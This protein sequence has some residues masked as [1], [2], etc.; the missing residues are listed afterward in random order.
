MTLRSIV[1]AG[2]VMSA[3]LMTLNAQVDKKRAL[4]AYERAIRLE[5]QGEIDASLKALDEA[6]LADPESLGALRRR[7]RLRLERKE[8]AD[9]AADFATITRLRP[10]EAESWQSLGEARLGLKDASAADALAKALELGQPSALLQEKHGEALSLLGDHAKAIEAFT[11]SIRLRIDRPEPYVGRGRAKAAQGNLRDAIEDFTAALQYSPGHAEGYYERAM[12]YGNLGMFDKAVDDFSSYLKIK[13]EDAAAYGF[14]GAAYD[15]LG[16]PSEAMADYNASLRLDPRGVRVLLAR[17]ELYARM[18]DHRKALEDRTEALRADPDNVMALVA[19]GGSYHMLG[20]HAQAVA[21]RTRAIQIDP[22]YGL[23][24]YARGAGY[25][26]LGDYEKAK[27]DLEEAVRLSPGNQEA[28]TVL[29]KTK[30]ILARKGEVAALPQAP[31]QPAAESKPVQLPADQPPPAPAAQPPE[32]PAPK[33]APEVAQTPEPA[34][35]SK[36]DPPP[37]KPAPPPAKPP[38][39]SPSP[40][41]VNT[42]A[43]ASMN[44]LGRELISKGDYEK[45]AK[46]LAD[47]VALDPG[48]AQAWNA[49]GFAKLLLRRYDEALADFDRALKIDPNYANAQQNRASVLRILGG[50]R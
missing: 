19:R 18:G 39:A 50:K 40:S 11:E 27:S 15:S 34:P 30:E 35:P 29:D 23:A 25:F 16:R 10:N 7:G 45:A 28:V 38:S 14:R 42:Q 37:S 12:A 24:W 22:N 46:V 2:A 4:E 41:S 47:A 6:L 3:A 33:T 32:P 9:A 48:M 43:A 26:L 21:D 17:G 49:L 13:P 44:K 5:S 36:P 20:E 31:A 8:F 1:L